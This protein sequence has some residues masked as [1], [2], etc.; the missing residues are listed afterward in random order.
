MS[1]L[2]PDDVGPR[3]GGDEPA[4]DY[5]KQLVMRVLEVAGR[6]GRI[7]PQE[8]QRRSQLAARALIIDDLIPLTR[9]L[10]ANPGSAFSNP[11][12]RLPV[13]PTTSAAVVATGETEPRDVAYGIFSGFKR[14]GQW[15][16]GDRLTAITFFGGG[17]L[18]LRN[19]IWTTPVIEV[20]V[21]TLFGGVDIRVPRGTTVVN[22]VVSVFGGSEVKRLK[23]PANGRQLIVK[24]FCAFGNVAIKGD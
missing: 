14:T 8:H 1:S 15:T 4:T 7:S 2:E 10:P 6:E 16:A 17:E 20:T 18:D 24:G 12:W 21:T 3:V 13:N 5:D 23:G 19:A 22:Q 11:S 9:D